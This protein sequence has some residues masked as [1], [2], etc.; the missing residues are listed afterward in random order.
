M[1]KYYTIGEIG[2]LYN[3]GPD[4]LRYYERKGLLYP[5]RSDAG[6]RLYQEEDLWRLNL[7]KDLRKLHFSINE[8]E[9][10]LKNRSFDSTL[11]LMKK[12]VEII[13]KEI[14]PLLQMKKGLQNK[15]SNL[16]EVSKLST[17]ETMEIKTLPERKILFIEGALN[18]DHEI[19]LAFRKIEGTDDQHMFLFGNKDMGVFLSEEGLSRGTYR[20]F[21]QAF[22]IVE[23]S[24]TDYD[25]LLGGGTYLSLTYRGPYRKGPEHHRNALNYIDGRGYQRTGRPLEIYRLDIHG[26]ADPDEFLTEI[27]IPIEKPMNAQKQKEKDCR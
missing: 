4:S 24:Q 20:E 15:I 3:I 12:K 5:K 22:F 7:I 14:E 11:E 26:T 10:Y 17:D 18:A 8:I 25:G 1:K 27:Q 13:E 9:E 23:D 6:Y 2:K 21:E 19:D 16:K